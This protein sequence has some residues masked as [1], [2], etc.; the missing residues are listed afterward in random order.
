MNTGILGKKTEVSP[1]VAA[2]S[3]GQRAMWFLWNMNRSGAEYGLPMAWTVPSTLDIT[4]LQGAMQDLVARHPIMRTTYAVRQGEPVQVIHP[5]GEAHLQLVDASGWDTE[6]LHSHL[7][8]ETHAPFDLEKG[9]VFRAHLFSRSHNEHVLLLNSHH[10]ASDTWTLIVLMEELGMLYRSRVAGLSPDLPPTGLS[11]TDYVLWQDQMLADSRGAEHWDYWQS[12]LAA[13]PVLDLPT[14]RP[15]PLVQTHNGA[16]YPFELSREVTTELRKLAKSEDVTFYTVLLATFYVLLYRYTGQE[17]LVV[18]SPR[19]G[20]P[21]VGYERTLGYFASPCALRTQVDG[22]MSY[23]RF[24]TQ[25]RKVLVGAKE[26]QDFPFPLLVERLGLQRDLSRSPVFQVAFTYQKSHLAHMQGV[27]AARMGFGGAQIDLSGLQLES[28]PLEQHSVKF[29]LD[30]VVEEVDGS[31]RAVCWYNTDL[32]NGETIG[33][34][35]DHYQG[36]LVGAAQNPHERL[37]R[38]PMLTTRELEAYSAWNA[39]EAPFSE[40]CAHHLFE[41][42]AARTPHAPALRFGGR[43]ISYDELNRRANRLAHHLRRLGLKKGQLVGLSMERRPELVIGVLAILKAGGAYLPLDPTYPQDRLTYMVED[44][45]VRLLLTQESLRGQLPAEGVQQVFVDGDSA[46]LEQ[47]PTDNLESWSTPDDLAYVIYTSGSTGRPKGVLLEHRGLSNLVLAQIEA[48]E[49]DSDS[50]VLQ[51]ASFS[52]DASVSEIF[53]TLCAGATLC[54][55]PKSDVIPGS[56]LVATLNENAV[57]VV[58]LPPTVLALLQPADVPTLKTVVTAGEACSLELAKRWA[59]GRR[60][61]NA[62][63]PTEATVGATFAHLHPDTDRVTIGRPI[64]NAK[65]YILDTFGQPTALG[66]AGEMYIA[67]VGLARGY[68]GRPDLTAERFLP[69]PFGQPGERM[70]KTGDLARWL[71]D[72]RLEFLGRLD[73]QVKI[74][75]FRIE[76]GELESV[77]AEYTGIREA[78]VVART[79]KNGDQRLVAYA[80]S[81]DVTGSSVADVKA[82]VQ[83]KLPDFMVPSAFIFLEKWPLTPNGKID[84]KALPA[85]TERKAASNTILPQ[86]PLEQQISDI[87]Q[88]VLGLSAVGID[89]NFFEVGGHSLSIVQIEVRIKEDLGLSVPTMDLFRF[90]TI[91]SLANHLR[92]TQ[93]T[94][95]KQ[96]TMQKKSTPSPTDT[97]IA[98]IGMAGRFPG[99]D[100]VDEF[101]N[102]LVAGVESVRDLSEKQLV[103]AGVDPTL[104]QDPRYVKRKGTLDGVEMFDAPFFGF[105]PREAQMM[106][107]QQRLFLE[108]GW[109]A[110]EHAGYS[111]HSYSG[112]I[113]V[114]GGT[115][116]PGYL[117]HHLKTNPESAA[118]LFQTTILNEKD[119]LS[120]RLAYKLNL[121]GPALTVQTACSTSLVAVHIACQQLLQGDCDMAMAG[122]VSIE[123]PH[124]TGYLYQEGHIL[125]PDG[126]CRAFDADAR[127]TVRGSGGAVV[128]LKRLADAEANGDTVWAVIKGSAINNDGSM[129]VGYTAPSVDGQADAIEQALQRAGVDPRTIGFVEAHGTGTPLGDPIEVAALTQTYR[130]YTADQGYCFLGSVKTNVGHLD[131]AAGVTG[132]IKAALA[133]HYGVVPPTLHFETPNPKLSL[134]TSPFVVNNQPAKWDRSRTS[135]RR[136]AVSSFGIGGTNAHVI[137]EEAP[138]QT[139][140][141]SGRPH[142]V[143]MLSAKSERALSAMTANLEQHLREKTDVNLADVAYTL[144]VGRTHFPHRQAVVC[145][146]RSGAVEALATPSQR[147]TAV[148]MP[149]ANSRVVFLFP[150]QGLQKVNMGRDLYE[151]E[152]EFRECV[153]ACAELLHPLLGLD[154]RTVLYPEQQDVEKSAARLAQTAITQ[155]A[156]FVVEYALSRLLMTWGVHPQ[157]MMGHSLGEYVAACLAGVMT[158]PDALKLVAARGQLVQKLPG[159]AMLAVESTPEQL[160]P[161]LKK[162]VDLAVVNGPQACVLAGTVEAMEALQ[163]ELTEAGLRWQNVRTSHAFHSSMLD[164]ILDEFSA[165]VS[166]I[167]L[168]EPKI[169]YVTNVTGTW[170]TPQEATDPAHWVRHMRQTVLFADGLHPLLQ[171]PGGIVLEVGPGQAFTSV[172]KRHPK[173]DNVVLAA[174]TLATTSDSSDYTTLLMTLGRLWIAGL[175]PEWENLYAHE[176][177]RRVALPVYPFDRHRYWLEARPTSQMHG[178]WMDEVAATSEA[179]YE[180]TQVEYRPDPKV[181]GPRDE[182]ELELVKVFEEVLG[183]APVGVTDSFFDLGGSSLSALSVMIRLEQVFGTSLSNAVLLESPTVEALAQV[184]RAGGKSS[185]S[186]RMVGI[187]TT[188]KQ[189]PI[190]CIHPYGGHTTGYF[191]LIR[192]LGADQPV[193]GIQSS[194]LQGEAV[195][196]TRFEDMATDYI[197]LIKSK[198][199]VGP[200]TLVGHSMGGCIAYEMAQ[201]LRQVGEEVALLALLDSRAQNFSVQPLYRNGEYGEMASKGWLSDEAVMLGIL[202]PKLSLD[203][204][205]LRGIPTEEHWLHALEAAKKQGLLPLGTGEDQIRNLL[206]VTRAN[207]EALRTYQPQPYQGDL[208]LFCGEDGFAKQFGEPELGWGDLVSG[209]FEAVQVPGNHHSI[210]TG[211]NVEAVARHLQKRLREL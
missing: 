143:L 84:R 58:T 89:D 55:A 199:P 176:A 94:E 167:D 13:P 47:E 51:F 31:L 61:V 39:T 200:Y 29:D 70:Y 36:L 201:Q 62:Y 198:Q 182:V 52:F 111:S 98:I 7:I 71:P 103:A 81:H 24:L 135:P 63:G 59:E 82:Y 79:E 14:D 64:A 210:M 75:G 173:K 53:T 5:E 146:S 91:R 44:A 119:F 86:D 180:P 112:R 104:F 131:A 110:L 45:E 170:V 80:I 185:G 153:D 17:D 169:P 35:V 32:W 120:T 18:G 190:F 60:F 49:I 211:T 165:I 6:Q 118:E 26:H 101:W 156:L 196:F 149:T 3:R 56:A 74:R 33:Y 100:N 90:P 171:E 175:T 126:H 162:G 87:W 127:G 19:F 191:E 195:P 48:F 38:L 69:D 147:Q 85:P 206:A 37:D 54:L 40:R 205:Q 88:D 151:S 83:S 68:L 93:N 113:G 189:A 164:P 132:L 28:Y 183:M 4:A 73:H 203:W 102:N 186:S 2:L 136:A 124:G 168:H 22:E 130:K 142:H 145:D 77:I 187:R 158:L 207:D 9:P 30:F 138:E 99:A 202:L 105:P 15:R 133:L 76:L 42:R 192:Y 128:V 121:R 50:R 72:G 155:P 1:V 194:G 114:Y 11:Y 134:E 27:A 141:S 67:G 109:Q 107:P 129:K 148:G 163:N 125:S 41:E 197:Q 97:D 139:T 152:P 46:A 115:G 95:S 21:P 92:T 43:E 10:I 23:S 123:V 137:L 57:T 166:E 78:L 122:G 66:V 159:G 150:G 144:Q 181:I 184:L 96:T 174:P 157:A 172:V 116:R 20:R 106:D 161:F 193:Y 34:L 208:L 108:V 177:R 178:E 140:T 25:V 117:L 179:E 188:G 204:E 8:E 16:G 12:L 209:R 154:L 65:V 160:H